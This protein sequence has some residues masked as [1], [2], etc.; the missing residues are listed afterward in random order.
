[1]KTNKSKSTLFIVVITLLVA[2]AASKKSCNKSF[3]I[4]QH[5]E[6]FANLIKELNTYYVDDID[7]A[8]TIKTGIDAILESLDPYTNFITEEE[9]EY[10]N[11]LT[12]GEYGGIG[13]VIGTRNNQNIVLMSYK[14]FPAHKSGLQIGDE[15]VKVNGENVVN[16]PISYI[17]DLLKGA[18]NTSVQLVV[19]RYDVAKPIKLELVR[20]KIK[21]KNVPYFNII[22]ED[23]GYIRLAEFT[24]SAAAEVKAALKELKERGA[25][26]LILDLRGNPGGILEEAVKVANLFIEEGLTVVETRGK[27][28]S[29]NSTY[30]T[31]EPAYD[32]SLPIIAL[33]NEGSASAA[34]IIAGVMQDYDRGVLIGESTFGKGLVQVTRPLS[35]NTQL[36]LTAAK[37]YIPSGR[38]IQ[39]IDYT[40]RDRSGRPEKIADSLRTAFKTKNGR[41]VYGGRGIDP[42]IEGEK[43]VWAPITVCLLGKGLVFDY[44]TIFHAKHDQIGSARTFE[45]SETQY[46]DFVKWLTDKDYDYTTEVEKSI[47]RLTEQAK[48]EKYYE[49]IKEQ[50]VSLKEKVQHNKEADLQTFK[51]EIKFILK[52]EIVARY[53][54]QEGIIEA[55]LD[56]D[57]DIKKA[58][59]L[60]KN[61]KQYDTIL[62]K[63]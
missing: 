9:L 13:A 3:Q 24:T 60:L 29:L 53:Y 10:Y 47:E 17:S 44:A 59:T 25:E 15:I 27:L 57:L 8:S 56:D 1:M 45:I 26:K 40:N 41:I 2:F 23:V 46:Q 55:T 50:I 62:K 49:A 7:P 14:D 21:L 31:E 28:A 34:E 42:D 36:K 12:T 43:Y 19:N 61:V 20:E 4:T 38:S 16:K 48:K 22:E 30:K 37:Y 63:Q 52:Q 39:A 32:S 54:L 58:L 33:V 51:E 18:P 6:I 5:L 35:Y 11:I